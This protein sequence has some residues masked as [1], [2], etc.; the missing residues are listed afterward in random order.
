MMQDKKY[1]SL[2]LKIMAL[3]NLFKKTNV[4][5]I[6]KDGKEIVGMA[7]NKEQG[8]RRHETD[9]LSDNQLSKSVRPIIAFWVL[10]LFTFMIFTRVLFKVE[11]TIEE[12][13]AILISLIIVLGFY[14]PGRTI[15]KWIK[16][17]L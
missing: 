3:K 11:F 15:E 6:V 12:Q 13:K 4:N 2:I 14:F 7:S 17:K 5:E 8:S 10:G 9:M 16:S 1:I